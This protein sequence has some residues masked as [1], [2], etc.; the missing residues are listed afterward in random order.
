MGKGINVIFIQD[1]GINESLA[2]TELAAYLERAGHRCRVVLEREE[3]RLGTRIRAAQPDLIV[4]PCNVFG[5]QWVVAMARR[6]AKLVPTVP[7]LVGGTHPTLS[8]DLIKDPAFTYQLVGEAE[9]AVTEL[10]DRLARRAPTN[11][12]QGIWVCEAGT[13]R[14]NGVAPRLD[15]L[16]ALPLPQRDVYYGYP[17]LKT[18]PWKKFSTGRGCE[19]RCSFCHN[20]HVRKLYCD[21]GFVRRKTV[22]RVLDEVDTVGHM[23]TLRWVHFADDLFVTDPAWLSTFADLYPER[24]GLPFS[25]NSSA[26]RMNVEVAQTLARAGC[27][28]VAIG[29]ETADEERRLRILKKPSPDRVLERAAAAVTGAGMELVTFLM[30][31]LPGEEL[32]DSLATLRF[33]R[34]LGAHAHRIM[35]AVPLPGT[36]MT[37]EAALD[38]HVSP[39]LAEDYEARI[40]FHD[41]P[42]G[43]FYR[44]A[45]PGAFENLANL[46][47]LLHRL[48]DAAVLSLVRLLP[49]RLTRIA[50]L[51]MSFQEKRLY[52]F[53]LLE[54]IRFYLHVGNPMHRTTNYVTLI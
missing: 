6:L 2:L 18:F 4:L 39:E 43:P 40:D 54:G 24:I 34:N 53:S 37:R 12:I 13:I 52:R 25:C 44:V 15:D 38:G 28:V 1:N 21:S 8:P 26:D 23:S 22:E 51:W 30:L 42:Y 50:R 48:P 9:I 11:D 27:R 31:A 35:M 46:A 47:P 32:A 17:F 36:E 33:S 14:D 49:K 19:N 29:V 16:S 7:L 20:E 45:E 10:A 41:N 3:R 5:A